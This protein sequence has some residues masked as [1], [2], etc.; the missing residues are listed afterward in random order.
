MKYH[1]RIQLLALYATLLIFI[2]VS[3]VFGTPNPAAIYCEELGYE[4]KIVD[5]PNGQYG[6]VFFPDGTECRAWDF[7]QGKCGQEFSYCAECGYDIVTVSDGEDPFS[8]EYAVCVDKN[9]NNVGTV[10]ELTKLAEKMVRD[11]GAIPDKASRGVSLPKFEFPVELPDSFDWRDYNGSDWVTSV[12]DQGDCGSCWAFCTIGS[13]DAIKNIQSDNPDLDLDLS[14]QYLVSDCSDAGNCTEGGWPFDAFE[15]IRDFGIPDED[16]MPYTA[17]DG[18]CSDRCSDWESRL[19]DVAEIFS[20]SGDNDLL[21]FTL[22]NI[23]PVS[24]VFSTS[25]AHWDGDILRCSSEQEP[26]HGVVIVGYNDI[27]GYW[28]VKNS[29]GADWNGDG[30][31]K[32]GYCE[33]GIEQLWEFSDDSGLWCDYDIDEDGYSDFCGDNCSFVYNPDQADDDYDGVG[34]PCD[35]CPV[36][37]PD[38]ADYDSDSIGDACDDCM[39]IDGDGFGDPG[40]AQNTCPEDNCPSAYNPDQTDN[41]EDGIGDACELCGDPDANNRINLI[42][43]TYI[44]Q[45]LYFGG[46]APLPN[47][48]AAD[49]NGN[50]MVNILDITYLISYLYREGSS[51]QLLTECCDPVW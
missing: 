3:G 34:N 47:E 41:D 12:K 14:E 5:G 10:V 30:Y 9:G 44:I 28:I 48:C 15:F 23:G 31:L 27:G 33:C 51:P 4:Y 8:R 50:G 35:N 18:P 6:I 20:M 7:L 29:W 16:C 24:V 1:T 32:I 40:F 45:F 49:V 38:Q 42:D 43:I 21:K 25:V 2:S 13:V 11:W 26:D 17:T 36:Y 19:V 22:I 37:N 39:D 46:P